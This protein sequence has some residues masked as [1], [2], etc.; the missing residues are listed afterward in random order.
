M[1]DRPRTG[2]PQ[3]KR[4]NMASSL[5]K[6][7]IHLIFHVKSTGVNMKTNDLPQIFQY[8]GGIIRGMDAIPIEIG[9]MP[10]HIHILTSLPK[11]MALTD[12]VR[13]IKANSSKWMKQRD[14]GYARFSWQD[15]YGAFSVSPSLLEK[16]VNYIRRQ[17]EHHKKRT[18]REEY[19]MFLEHYGIEYDERYAF[20]D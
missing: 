7:N 4:K 12:F 10:D 15:G 20:G 6:I 14:V 3:I 17:E 2:V 1:G 16:T 19:K 11:S 5:V 13:D 8:I 18:F 9:G